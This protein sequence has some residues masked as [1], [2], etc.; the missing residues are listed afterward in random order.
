MRAQ[1]KVTYF[2]LRVRKIFPEEITDD[3]NLDNGIGVSQLGQ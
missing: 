2:I 1:R 3:L